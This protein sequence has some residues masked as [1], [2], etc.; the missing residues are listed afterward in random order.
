[1]DEMPG[2]YIHM[3]VARNALNQNPNPM[4]TTLKT[5][6]DAARIFNSMGGPSANQLS[7][8]ANDNPTAVALGAIGP[9]MFFL[10]LDFQNKPGLQEAAN[11]ILGLYKAWDENFSGPFHDNLDPIMQNAKTAANATTGSLL[12]ATTKIFTDGAN[13]LLDAVEVLL[14]RQID[15]FSLLSSGIITG[16]DEQTF[17]W[18]DMFHYR[19]TYEFAHKLW[20]N[21]LAAR[22]QT[23]QA[24]ALGWMTHLAT[25]VTGHSFVNEK[26][27]GPY[28]LHWQR[29]HLIENHM[30][31][32]IYDSEFAMS[33]SQ[34]ATNY[35]MIS[36]S[37]LHLWLAFD[38]GAVNFFDNSMRPSYLT[39][40]DSFSDNSR[41]QA[42]DVDSDM[43]DDL[44]KI[45]AKTI[46]DVYNDANI[47]VADPRGQCASHPTNLSNNGFPKEDDI[48]T[49]YALLYE[50]VKYTT[51]D[52]YMLQRPGPPSPLGDLTLPSYPPFD[53]SIDSNPWHDILE[54]L[55]AMLA[56]VLFLA[57]AALWPL[58]ELTT[59][60]TSLGTY[61][62]REA[63]YELVE[64]PLY[65]MWEALHWYLSMTG[66]VYPFQD[67][68]SPSLITLGIGMED[69][70]TTLTQALN[71]PMGGLMIPPPVA[72]PP[73]G[74]GLV[75]GQRTPPMYPLDAVSDD[76]TILPELD[77]KI[78]NVN[79]GYGRVMS[80][81]MIRQDLP[82]E[83]LRPWLFPDHNNAGELILPELPLTIPGIYTKGNDVTVLFN[84]RPGNQQV[85]ALYEKAGS[86]TET[87]DITRSKR[88]NNL[89][90]DP[91]DYSCYLIAMLTRNDLSNWA[92][93]PNDD[94][95]N[96]FLS[97]IP[98]FDLDS[99]RGYGYLCW[100]WLRSKD[101]MAIPS[102]Y[103]QND[104][105]GNYDGIPPGHINKRGLTERGEF[106]IKELMKRGMIV[107]IEH[108]SEKCVNSVLD[109]AEHSNLNYPVVASHFGPRDTFS[110]THEYLKT[111][112]QTKRILK[113]GGVIGVGLHENSDI[114]AS[115][116]LGNNTLTSGQQNNPCIGTSWSWAQA[117]LYTIK[118]MDGKGGVGLGTDM[119]G[120]PETIAPRFGTFVGDNGISVDDMDPKL[121]NFPNV[122]TDTLLNFSPG[123]RKI[124]AKTQTN[125][126]SYDTPIQTLNY[127]RFS[128]DG[129]YNEYERAA[130]MGIAIFQSGMDPNTAV[131]DSGLVFSEG[132]GPISVAKG[133]V[134]TTDPGNNDLARKAAFI[135]N[136]GGPAPNASDPM[137]K[138]FSAISTVWPIWQ[139]M[140][141]GMNRQTTHATNKLKRSKA[142]T[143]EFD[144]NLDGY[145]HY[146][147]LPDFIQDLRNLGLSNQDLEPL[148]NSAE[149]YIQVWEN[150]LKKSGA[151][152]PTFPQINK[153]TE[154]IPTPHTPQGPV[155]IRY[156]DREEKFA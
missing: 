131:D 115:I 118:M 149:A 154:Q 103:S 110:L 145:A 2:W 105:G 111:M 43:P 56:W 1:M 97:P 48:R 28:R 112:E 84:S 42:W 151:I 50:F 24:Y 32:K 16:G 101:I 40:D 108:M 142:G 31:A 29:H 138:W 53:L 122:P 121:K 132:G 17:M 90:G 62:I 116:A 123:R 77:Q 70:R 128:D 109:I 120:L 114:P 88:G 58:V 23:A 45:L 135:V 11:F 64:I 92:N 106:F 81:G 143:R 89:L 3:D 74:S 33:G 141:S 59:I 46:Q 37:A 125:G 47:M 10:L 49:A 80:D 93:K 5:N 86:A 144:F 72:D 96:N 127:Y 87:D 78:K 60:L 54:I 55:I 113:L 76:A 99:D 137:I 69:V 13:V 39:G 104:V 119:N 153:T 107:D 67:E 100:D 98:N 68:I 51:T 65:N 146:G 139:A 71:D 4:T 63:I 148:L 57:E 61:P 12:D 155:K 15:V 36:C 79:C 8:I 134:D 126:V 130:W 35:Q 38:G 22:N 147:M 133:F 27:G 140:M 150:S 136:M 25:D 6:A 82:S 75:P 83:F 117:Y 41:R 124:Q 20:Q 156:I 129:I 85:R 73:E 34:K 52:F 26:C 66:F 21:S 44:V 102:S 95:Q 9:D 18:S 19:K 91:V 14:T 152:D 94:T 30:D 7:M